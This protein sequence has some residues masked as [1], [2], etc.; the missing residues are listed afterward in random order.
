MCKVSSPERRKASLCLS[1]AS[2]KAG[3][4]L[5]AVAALVP[6]GINN[7]PEEAG[8]IRKTLDS[9]HCAGS[10][11]GSLLARGTV[12]TVRISCTKVE[13]QDCSPIGC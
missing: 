9:E 3:P 6:R 1:Y 13:P 4:C 12:I 2:N 5:C 11:V 7:L 10:A 8:E